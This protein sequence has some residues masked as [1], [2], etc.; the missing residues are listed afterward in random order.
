MILA[1]I[2]WPGIVA[3]VEPQ[4]SS[5]SSYVSLGGL[6]AVAAFGLIGGLI[7]NVVI[8]FPSLLLLEFLGVN[9]LAVAGIVGVVLGGLVYV[10]LGPTFS[11]VPIRES[12]PLFVF[13]GVLGG[14]CGMV[15][16]YRARL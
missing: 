7:G 5:T 10:A 9:T 1:P 11:E 12:W 14:A 4:D 8:G 3:L 16:S 13:F 15:A 6:F 2:L